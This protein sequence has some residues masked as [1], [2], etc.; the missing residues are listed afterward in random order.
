M[1]EQSVSDISKALKIPRGTVLSRL[2]T[3]RKKVKKG[4]EKM[5][6]YQKN[7]YQPELLTIGISGRTGQKDEPFSCVKDSLYQNILILAYDKP[8]T[9]EDLSKALGVPMVFIE[10]NVRELVSSEL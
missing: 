7:S 9:I 3:G 10:E 1:K 4:V 6:N 5:E 2:D 8:I